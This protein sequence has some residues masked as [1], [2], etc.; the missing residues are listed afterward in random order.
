[1]DG[2]RWSGREEGVGAWAMTV[3]E[4]GPIN[5]LRSIVLWRNRSLCSLIFA[6]GFPN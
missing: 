6:L 5:F 4:Y 3:H 2:F 1:M